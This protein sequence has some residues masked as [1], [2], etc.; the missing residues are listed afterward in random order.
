MKKLYIGTSGYVYSH[1]E[2][3]FY[4]DDLPKSKKLEYYCQHF[5]TVELNNTFYRL[6]SKKVFESW[7]KRT[8]KNFVFAV[9]VSRFIT[10]IKKLKDCKDSWEIFLKRALILKEKL[11]PLLF[12]L[13][14]FWKKDTKRLK[15]FLQMI[16]KTYRG[17]TPVRLKFAFE[18]RN[19]TWCDREIYDLLKKYNSAWVVV[20]SPHW[21]KV[22]KVTAN[23]VY[24]RMHGSKSLFSSNYTKKELKELADWIKKWKKKKLKIFVYFNNDAQ[25]FAVKNA[26]ELQT[27]IN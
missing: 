23:F 10:H 7:Y 20:D 16:H 11:G 8:P 21:P 17:Q 27:L 6:P 15:G 22:L 19:E 5:K 1:W 12:Q 26:K 2:G 13:P 9:K 4:P 3:I 25:G 24:V 14:P 18:F